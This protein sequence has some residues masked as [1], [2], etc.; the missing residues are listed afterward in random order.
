MYAIES[1]TASFVLLTTTSP[2]IKTPI[3]NK[4]LLVIFE[5][6]SILFFIISIKTVVVIS[7]I[8][9]TTD[10]V[11]NI[12]IAYNNILLIFS[13]LKACTYATET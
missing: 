6:K 5:D 9:A 2:T 10:V 4:I 8:I 12:A 13:S 3:K 1:A 11:I 7:I